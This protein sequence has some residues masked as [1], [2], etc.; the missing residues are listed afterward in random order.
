MIEFVPSNKLRFY[1]F[2]I[3]TL[4]ASACL[5][6]QVISGQ[7]LDIETNEPLIGANIRL[8]SDASIGTITDFEGN[9]SFEVPNL[10]DILII[11]YT[12]YTDR[13]EAISGRTTVNISLS[14]GQILDELVIVGYGTVK[15]ED[16]TG[17]I[18]TVSSKDFNKG[19]ITSPQQLLAGKVAGVSITNSGDPGGGS[20]IRIRGE[21]SLTASNDPLIVVDGVPLDNTSTA[22]G[23]N[24]LNVV[25]PNDIES[26]TVLKD[27]SATA[28]YGNRAS[29]GVLLITTKK[30]TLGNKIRVG[31]NGNVSVG[32]PTG[33]IDVLEADEFVSLIKSDYPNQLQYVDTLGNTDWQDEIYQQAVGMDHNLSISGGIGAF[34][35][36]VSAGYTDMNGL[37]KT[38]NFNRLTGGINVNPKFL[39]SRLQVNLGLKAMR[40]NNDFADRGAIGNSL[41]Y[42]PTKAVLDSESKYGGYSAWIGSNGLPISLAPKNPLALLNQ[43]DDE[44]TVNRYIGNASFDYRFAFLPELRAN[45]NLGYDRSN[46][47][48]FKFIDTT[49]AFTLTGVDNVFNEQK[50]NS[51][52]EFY[53][54]Y[55]KDISKNTIDV[56]G[57]YSWQRFG[58]EASNDD[59][60]LTDKIIFSKKTARELFLLSFYGRVNYD[61]NDKLFFTFTTRA[62]GTSRFGEGNKWGVFPAGA[63]GYKLIDNDRKYLNYTKLRLGWGVTGQQDI[64][65]NFYAA[66]GAYE[67]SEPTAG[68]QFGDD[69]VNTLRANGYDGE[70]KWETTTT[71]NL[72]VDYSIIKDRISGSLDIYQRY[73]KDLLINGVPLAA[74]TNLT[75][76]LDTNIGDMENR[77]VEVALNLTP[78]LKN[79]FQWD[80]NLNMSY[81]KN[82]ITRLRATEDPNY[83]GILA[84]GIAGGVGS[85]I[86]IH[87]VGF[88]PYSFYVFKQK[89]NAD[90]GIIPGEYEDLN[91]DGVINEDDKYR[92]ESR[93]PVFGYGVA[94]NLSYGDF[95]FSLAGRANVGNYMYNNVVTD[96]GW[97]GRVE[98][99]SEVATNI[100][101]SALDNNVTLQS[102]VTFSDH[103]VT[104]A[105][106]FRLDHVTLGYDL[107]KLLKKNIRIYTTIQNP[108]VITNYEGLDPEEFSGI[109]NNLYPR[110]RTFVFGVSANF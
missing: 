10:D 16:A 101:Q 99:L 78:V 66:L 102:E 109:D 83:V 73:T 5:G 97:L 56:L 47:D 104:N 49:A 87:T 52:L 40:S 93:Q 29:A 92:F 35:F 96:I 14:A 79:K 95:S 24:N 20:S 28:I 70:I 63:L 53:L 51:L 61:Y 57:G 19:A 44:S 31:Y 58:F 48:G 84:G 81:N 100:H 80:I 59:S 89:Y 98:N 38:D 21:S 34:P 77:G 43:T 32:N 15:R 85:N 9:Y 27:A 2:F 4:V 11:S 3:F 62:D 60:N 18:Q 22:G 37:L 7:I 39:D 76:V 50:E 6:Q 86:Q 64:G 41:S 72:G 46:S 12:G 67:G 45:L 8:K 33:R 17:S 88:R 69:F 82:E 30:G 54:N 55:K 42:A 91:S 106:F 36:R 68:Y 107:T 71:Y 110:P 26:I 103:F 13:E 94:T 65:N 25:N 75:N 108:I 74:G 105:S 90:G 1:V 23:R